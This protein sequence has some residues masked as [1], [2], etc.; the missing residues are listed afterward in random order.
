MMAT[1]MRRSGD[2][3][4]VSPPPP[5]PASML[6]PNSE[7]LSRFRRHCVVAEIV[8]LFAGVVSRYGLQR[9]LIW[10]DELASSCSL[11]AMLGSVSH[12]RRSEAYADAA[13]VANASPHAGLISMIMSKKRARAGSP[14]LSRIGPLAVFAWRRRPSSRYA[15]SEECDYASEHRQQRT[16]SMPVRPTRI[17]GRCSPYVKR[18][19]RQRNES[20]QRQQCRRNSTKRV[21]VGFKHRRR[22]GGEGTHLAGRAASHRA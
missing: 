8:T 5:F 20:P 21:R 16:G 19:L 15:R 6:E 11:A 10:S 9:P 4:M 3:E 17:N 7:R 1:P 2:G 13:V 22:N 14:R 18:R 12:F